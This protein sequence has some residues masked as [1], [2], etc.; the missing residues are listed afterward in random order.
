[1]AE[2]LAVSTSKPWELIDGNRFQENLEI[3]VVKIL[4]KMYPVFLAG[5]S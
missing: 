1:M 2:P 5:E 3:P 4:F